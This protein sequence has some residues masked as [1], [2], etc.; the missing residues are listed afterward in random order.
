MSGEVSQ[1]ISIGELSKRSGVACSAIRYYESRQLI[2]SARTEGGQRKYDESVELTLKQVRFAQSVGFPLSEIGDLLGPLESGEPLFA[3][4]QTLA[5]H[6]LV[7]L[8][9]V[10]EQAQEMKR[11]L[12]Q[13]L[14]CRCA[15][16]ED[17]GLL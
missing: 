9:S 7:E 2:Q 14:E 10:I 13:A 16:A 11:R 1:K 5:A 15:T 6:K 3:H 17:C 12:Q 4:W 8:D